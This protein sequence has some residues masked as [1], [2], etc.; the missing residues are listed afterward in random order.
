[1]LVFISNPLKKKNNIPKQ[2][3]TIGC[4]IHIETFWSESSTITEFVTKGVYDAGPVRAAVLL[5]FFVKIFPT[6]FF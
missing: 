1:M 6:T 5:S 3:K 4:P 2:K